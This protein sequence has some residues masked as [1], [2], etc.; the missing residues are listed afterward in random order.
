MSKF[1]EGDEIVC[2]AKEDWGG[3]VVGNTYRVKECGEFGYWL[4]SD[5]QDANFIAYMLDF[6]FDKV[7]PGHG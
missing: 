6:D 7:E 5:D 1:K 3:F 4:D 2:V